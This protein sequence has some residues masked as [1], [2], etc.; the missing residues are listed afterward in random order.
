MTNCD[1]CGGMT[2][3]QYKCFLISLRQP[4]EDLL[5]MVNNGADKEAITKKIEREIE[6]YDKKLML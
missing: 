1:E 4:W 5:E 6:L 3:F 2:D